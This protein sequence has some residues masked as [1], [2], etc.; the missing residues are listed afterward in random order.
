[1]EKDASLKNNSAGVEL[2]TEHIIYYS[3]PSIKRI[4]TSSFSSM[5]FSTTVLVSSSNCSDRFCQYGY[6]CLIPSGLCF[7]YTC[8]FLIP[9]GIMFKYNDFL[10]LLFILFLL[11]TAKRF[12]YN[13]YGCN[14]WE[15]VQALKTTPQELNSIQNISYTTQ[16][17]Q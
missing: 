12:N 1:M 14:P 4:A 6:C 13:N 16:T 8:N 3:N 7:S 15:R 17:L 11:Y 2:Y 10:F 9:Y 5:A